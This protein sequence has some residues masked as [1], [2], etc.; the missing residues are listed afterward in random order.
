MAAVA[1]ALLGAGWITWFLPFVL[2]RRGGEAAKQLDRRARWGI[3]LQACA[4]A[5][6][7][8][9]AFWTRSPQLWQIA[10]SFVFFLL[11]C[12]LS[13]RAVGSLGKQWRLDAGLSSDHALI[14]SGPYRIVRHP[15][16]TSILL[17]LWGTGVLITPPIPLL[18]ATVVAIVGTEIRVRTEDKLLASHFGSEFLEYKRRVAAYV[19]MVR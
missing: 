16:Y 7:W 5:I 15:I 6:L 1:Y 2:A 9:N 17:V 3:L 18:I 11:A 13:W 19:P 12:F 14:T 10:V 4:Y 8:Q